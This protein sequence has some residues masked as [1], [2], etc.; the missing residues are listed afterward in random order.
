MVPYWSDTLKTAFCK[1][2]LIFFDDPAKGIGLF[3]LGLV[4]TTAIV[5]TVRSK[6]AF[7]EHWKSNIA[8]PIAGGVCTWVLVFLYFLISIPS[9]DHADLARQI[10]RAE[11]DMRS[12]VVSKEGAEAR[13]IDLARQKNVTGIVHGACRVTEDQINPARAQQTC[14]VGSPAPTA[15]DRVLAINARLTEGDRNRFSNALSDFERSL[16][17]GRDLFYKVNTEGAAVRQ[18]LESGILNNLL[19]H[20]KLLA[21]LDA[22]GW[23][24]QKAF[25]QLR[26]KWQ[27]IFNDQSEYIFGDNP[28][29][30]GPN[31]L[32]NAVSVY[33]EFLNATKAY[34]TNNPYFIGLANNEYQTRMNVFS[35]WNQECLARLT[36]MR[37]SI[38]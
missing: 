38:R 36:E 15:R 17:D 27:Q 35:K 25:P 34:P 11:S 8:I 2:L 24:Y 5:W 18:E 26:S 30:Q 20:A 37:N 14:P 10:S 31:A 4:V 6:E 29:N 7:T 12:A 28:D 32:I 33:R 1:S 9:Q 23:K 22:E 3:V 13:A 19:T 16:T 21:D